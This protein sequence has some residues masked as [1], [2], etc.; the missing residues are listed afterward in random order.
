MSWH[1]ISKLILHW[2]ATGMYVRPTVAPLEPQSHLWYWSQPQKQAPIKECTISI[3]KHILTFSPRQF[4]SYLSQHWPMQQHLSYRDASLKGR[5]SWMIGRCRPN[6][7]GENVRDMHK[8]AASR[9]WQAMLH[10]RSAILSCA[11][12]LQV[13]FPLLSRCV[14]YVKLSQIDLRTKETLKQSLPRRLAMTS[15]C[16]HNERS[17]KP[18]LATH[19]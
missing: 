6:V 5:H 13:A 19:I 10:L 16:C 15:F 18:L 11:A 8:A 2:T 17:V 9:R 1:N 7:W 12:K 3:L 14:R 4:K